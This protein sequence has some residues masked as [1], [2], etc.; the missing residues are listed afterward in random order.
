[1][2]GGGLFGCSRNL[3]GE[4]LIHHNGERGPPMKNK[5]KNGSSFHIRDVF[6]SPCLKFLLRRSESEDEKICDSGK[7]SRGKGKGRNATGT[8]VINMLFR[9]VA[10]ISGQLHISEGAGISLEPRNHFVKWVSAFRPGLLGQKR[11]QGNAC[12]FLVIDSAL[13]TLST[14]K[15]VNPAQP[16]L[17]HAS[18]SIPRPAAQMKGISGVPVAFVD[19]LAILPTLEDTG[20]AFARDCCL[21]SALRGSL[22]EARGNSDINV[23]EKP[24]VSK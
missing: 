24:W 11:P 18:A 4:A 1:M 16:P 7:R 22:Y 6:L 23:L 17:L 15:R 8:C 9:R 12:S 5:V 19:V 3:S 2:G 20:D 10:E 21:S 14:P 13:P